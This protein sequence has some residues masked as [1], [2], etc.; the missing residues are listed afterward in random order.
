MPMT[1]VLGATILG[2]HVNDADMP[3]SIVEWLWLI[4]GISGSG[5]FGIRFFIQWM[6]SEKHK[7]SRIPI[8]FWWLS[9]AGTLMAASYFIHK[10]Q[11]VALL[12]NG[13]QLIP[14]TRNLILIYRK[15][16]QTPPVDPDVPVPAT[17]SAR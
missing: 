10:Q 16:A 6:H 13:P 7:E 11:W 2:F 14:Y 8:S 3:N 17:A 15:R 9:V 4:V 12:G 5:I 1:F